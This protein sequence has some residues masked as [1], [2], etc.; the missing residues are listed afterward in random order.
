MRILLV[1]DNVDHR[2][3]M[4]LAL[5]EYDLTWQ[6]EGV[7]SGEEALRRL[8]EGEAYDVVFLDYSLP[9]RDGLE[10]LEEIRRGEAP[11]PVVMVTGRGD[12]QVA[13]EAM[14][15]G[16]YDY[17]VKGEGYRQRLSVVAQ[18]ALE[19][20]QLAVDRR[21]AEVALRESEER[22]R[23]LVE[24]TP[25]VI[26]SLSAGDGTITSLNPAF[27]RITGWSR[28]EWLGKPFM[29]IIHPDDL[30]LAAETFQQVSCGEATSPYEL[31]ILSKSGEYLIGEF[32]SVPNIEK[33]KVVGEFGIARDITDR[34]RAE[35]ALRESEA[36]Y[37]AVMEQSADGICLTDVQT[38][39]LLEA[40]TA[41]QRMLGYTPEEIQELSIYD[42]IAADREDIDRRFEGILKRESPPSLERQLRRKDGS[43]V[44][45]W[46]STNVISY[47]GREL[48][49]TLVRDVTEH[50]RAQEE[51][52]RLLKRIRERGE[53]LRVLSQQLVKI[54]E[55]ERH[56]LA[57]ELHDEVGQNL[58]A[59]AINLSILR[60]K[61]P[62]ESAA[63]LG[64]R[65]DDSQV[66]VEET[67]HRIRDV[68]AELRPPLLDDYGLLAA[69]RWYAQRFSERTGIPTLT[70][71]ENLI[72]R[73]PL[74]IETTLFRIAQEAL[75]N[76][77]K[78]AR[79][80]Q[81]TVTLEAV[82][83]EICLTIADNGTGFDPSSLH[84]TVERPGYGLMSM[85]ERT[86]AVGGRFRVESTPEKGTRLIVEVPRNN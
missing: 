32:K 54:Q 86:D 65:L 83:G 46:L 52:E 29:S 44:E 61:L 42:L 40:N 55:T 20:H 66:L 27:E 50:K 80:S 49:C 2:E 60:S 75:T 81:V 5:T 26:Y 59:L 37:R 38:R 69:L 64:A 23:R 28:A 43:L 74:A 19:A 1:E 34:K 78:H 35:E 63:K 70:E 7:A 8:A 67:I 41:L 18:R 24:N 76:V 21:R 33:G 77:T 84:R 53:Q 9:G 45:V 6:V 14:K 57:R 62:A 17:V 12:E 85:Q 82:G 71:G 11:P 4:R 51:R 36:R 16:A 13:V 47:G 39:Y 22:Y 58:T 10:V 73:L 72:P 15:G 30:S 68:M 56:S 48:I 31:R 25:E 3:L 79:A